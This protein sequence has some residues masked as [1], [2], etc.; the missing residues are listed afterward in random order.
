MPSLLAHASPARAR[1]WI[2]ERSNSAKHAYHV[3]HGLPGRCRGVESLLMQEQVNAERD[4]LP[5][6]PASAVSW[7]YGFEIVR[8]SFIGRQQ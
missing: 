2:M 6:G 4:R 1:S 7:W 3:K 5:A 8:D